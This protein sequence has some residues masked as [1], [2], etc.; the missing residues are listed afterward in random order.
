MASGQPTEACPRRTG[1]AVIVRKDQVVKDLRDQGH[2]Q[3]A[4]KVERELPDDVDTDKHADWLKD[5][6]FKE[7]QFKLSGEYDSK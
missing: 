4:D 5:L 2:A 6:D 7:E 1:A 3:A